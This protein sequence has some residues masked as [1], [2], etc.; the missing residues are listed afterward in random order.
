MGGSIPLWVTDSETLAKVLVDEV[1]CRYGVPLTLH[2][3]QGANLNSEVITSLCKQLGIER[4]RT[5]AYHPQSN[6]QVERFNRTL[7]SMLSKVVSENQKDWDIHLPKVLF[8]YRTSIHEST[9]FS[10]FFVTYGWSATLPIDVMLGW[11]PLSS[12]GG[13][14][15][16]EFVEQ[17]GLSIRAAYNKVHQNI[18]EAHRTNKLRHDRKESGCNFAVWDLIWLYV[19]AV[20]PKR[21]NPVYGEVPTLLS[22]KLVL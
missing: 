16:P 12:E 15:I 8:A 20:K 5:T 21:T 14:G 18:E 3:D 9:G 1:V 22:T 6:G 7:E 11:I 19:P 17:V 4:T 2:S 13:K 10:A